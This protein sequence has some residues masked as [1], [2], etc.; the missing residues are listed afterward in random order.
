MK[1]KSLI[2]IALTAL[3]VACEKPQ[4]E[5]PQPQTQE[6]AEQ[7]DPR[8][9]FVGTYDYQATGN[10][11]LFANGVKLMSMPLNE[12]DTFAIAKEG[13]EDKVVINGFYEPINA[14]VYGNKM[15]LD[16]TSYNTSYNSIEIRMSLSQGSATLTG[17]QLSWTTDMNGTGTYNNISVM[18][19]GTLSV[20]AIKR[21]N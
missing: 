19:T 6:P 1:I 3:C 18:G 13:D 10:V 17:N 20:L 15:L 11:D 12:A 21:E 16:V 9:K 2:L 8:D 4:A 5:E 7:T 14:T